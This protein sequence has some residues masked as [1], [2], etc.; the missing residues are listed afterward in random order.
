MHALGKCERIHI[1]IHD[2]YSFLHVRYNIVIMV[3]RLIV[4]K[5]KGASSISLTINIYKSKFNENLANIRGFEKN[6]G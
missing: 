5:W 6:A 3:Y 1:L 4:Y 2:L